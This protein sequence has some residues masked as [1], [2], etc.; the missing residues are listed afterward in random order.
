MALEIIKECQAE[1]K[2]P[3]KSKAKPATKILMT[4][5]SASR[6]SPYPTLCGWPG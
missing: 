1:L 5:V 3:E 6:K 2:E 4:C